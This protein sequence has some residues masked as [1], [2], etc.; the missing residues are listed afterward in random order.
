MK[1]YVA[2][3]APED[4]IYFIVYTI[5]NCRFWKCQDKDEK[6]DGHAGIYEQ[7]FQWYI[8]EYGWGRGA[9]HE[10][11]SHFCE[12]MKLFFILFLTTYPLSIGGGGNNVTCG[13]PTNILH[14]VLRFYTIYVL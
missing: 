14:A 10:Q 13:I 11:I 1:K 12:V 2:L 4:L 3:L 7:V 6:L 5:S 8:P 9:N